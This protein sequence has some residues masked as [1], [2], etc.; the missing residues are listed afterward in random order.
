V[1]NLQL[2]NAIVVIVFGS[3]TIAGCLFC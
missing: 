1:K 3:R 2:I